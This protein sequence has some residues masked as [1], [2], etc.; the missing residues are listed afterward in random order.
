M[1][2]GESWAYVLRHRLG[3]QAEEIEHIGHVENDDGRGNHS[4]AP[5]VW[6]ESED[7][8]DMMV[9]DSEGGEIDKRAEVQKLKT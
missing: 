5:L 8:W 2:L 7:G 9:K 6:G 1:L 4:W 3:R